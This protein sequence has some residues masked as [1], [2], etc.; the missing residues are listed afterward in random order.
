MSKVAF[1]VLASIIILVVFGGIYYF[2]YTSREIC[3]KEYLSNDDKCVCPSGYVKSLVPWLTPEDEYYCKINKEWEDFKPCSKQTDCQEGE[4]CSSRYPEPIDFR[5]K[6]PSFKTDGWCN[7]N[8]D[9][10][11]I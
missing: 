8:G 1:I 9:C 7:I 5:C 3:T 4:F 2:N 11:A 6:P 10:L